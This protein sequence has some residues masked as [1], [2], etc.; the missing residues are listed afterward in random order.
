[1]VRPL[2]GKAFSFSLIAVV[3]ACAAPQSLETSRS[4]TAVQPSR[5][6]I[7]DRAARTFRA[8]VIDTVTFAFGSD[9][10]DPDAMGVLDRQADWIVDHPNV[11]F[12]VYGHADR[13]GSDAQNIRL[14]ERR[15][16]RVVAY[17]I[18][19]G[20]DP[21]RLT[22]VIS[23]GEDLPIINTDAPERRN[24]RV[25]TEVAGAPRM[26]APVPEDGDGN[27]WPTQTR[28]HVDMAPPVSMARTLNPTDFQESN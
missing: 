15:A 28:T 11:F 13:P 18:S 10:L 19:R 16:D 20:V 27:W 25:V 26:R 3:A 8:E 4:T 17:L 23:H 22:A 14:A 9:R 7:S 21:D 24:R 1:M 6:A 2:L 12:R 5:L